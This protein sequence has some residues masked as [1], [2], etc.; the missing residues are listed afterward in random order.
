QV[1]LSLILL[2]DGKSMTSRGS[3]CSE[4]L[5]RWIIPSGKLVIHGITDPY[6]FWFYVAEAFCVLG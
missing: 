5:I 1:V 4:V 2:S 3:W 6:K